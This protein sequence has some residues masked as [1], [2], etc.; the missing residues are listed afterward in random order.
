MVGMGWQ[1]EMVGQPHLDDEDGEGPD[2]WAGG[3][4][5]ELGQPEQSREAAPG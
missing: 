5:E 1:E 2:G 3:A 4:G